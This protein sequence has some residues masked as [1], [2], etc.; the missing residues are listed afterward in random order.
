[1]D[2][3]H[4]DESSVMDVGE[5]VDQMAALVGLPLCPEHRPGVVENFERIRAV[6]QLV[7]A[8]PLPEAVES[9]PIFEP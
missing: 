9:A 5:W 3:Q 4:R 8:F 6:A 7:T 1:M 2:E